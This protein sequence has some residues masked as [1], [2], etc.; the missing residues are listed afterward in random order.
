MTY[1]AIVGATF[2]SGSSSGPAK[3]GSKEKDGS[4]AGQRNLFSLLGDD[5]E[6][7]DTEAVEEAPS[8]PV[9]A[10]PAPEFKKKQPKVEEVD[11]A[12]KKVCCSLWTK[13]GVLLALKLVCSWTR[14]SN[15]L[16]A[17]RSQS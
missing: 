3:A 15:S 8:A 4:A 13:V 17:M 1:D 5:D 10:A 9:V 14:C 2:T 11:E 7:E 12:T 16:R 6:E